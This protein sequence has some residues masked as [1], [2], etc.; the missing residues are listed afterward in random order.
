VFVNFSKSRKYFLRDD[1]VASTEYKGK[2]YTNVTAW[3]IEVDGEDMESN[4]EEDRYNY[5]YCG[6][7]DYFEGGES[8]GKYHGSYAQD[9]ARKSDDFIDDVLGGDPSAY[10]NID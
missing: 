4:A 9:V 7:G 6:D 3:K 5:E 2:W 1:Y 8:Y 10:W